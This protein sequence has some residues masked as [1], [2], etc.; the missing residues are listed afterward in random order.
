MR[1]IH[2]NPFGVQVGLFKSVKSFRKRFPNAPV[3]VECG[4]RA[5]AVKFVEDGST[6]FAMIIPE[7]SLVSLIAHE[8]SHTVDFIMENTGVPINVENTEIRAY[9]LGQM[10]ADILKE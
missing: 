9:L 6:W 1:V 3:D 10:I 2:V 8:C 5:Y 7:N 4:A